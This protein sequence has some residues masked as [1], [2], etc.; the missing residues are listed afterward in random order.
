MACLAIFALATTAGAAPALPAGLRVDVPFA[1]P[2]PEIE[3]RVATTSAELGKPFEILAF[4]Q[5]AEGTSLESDGERTTTDYFYVQRADDLGADA[6]PASKIQGNKVTI[7]PLAVGKLPINLYWRIHTG[8][9]TAAVEKPSTVVID[10]ALPPMGGDKPAPVDIKEPRRARPALWPWLLAALLG[11]AAWEFYRR[12]R[13]AAASL[14]G[15]PPP[16][17][18]RPAETIA[19]SE[20]EALEASGLWAR[21]LYKDYYFRLTETLRRYLER[22]Y[23]IPA[24]RLTTAELF[25][26]MRQAE[27]DRALA[28]SFKDIF[29]RADLVKF[30]KIA[31]E[32]DWGAKDISGARSL[33]ERTT[34]RDL[35][36]APA[37]EG[38]K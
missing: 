24:T 19:F 25:R 27:L 8:S 9:T 6:A 17:D 31:P 20:L 30:A 28:V 14:A 37:A 1:G 12:R 3:I 11:A 15:A 35:I 33:V 38:P 5:L 10:V 36:G 18:D 22:R 7:L 13:A 32:A 21:A 26:H 29:D 23:G 34:P 16:P 2:D 4:A